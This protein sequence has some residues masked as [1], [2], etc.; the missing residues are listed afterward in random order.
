MV[1]PVC[2][3]AHDVGK[4]CL[5]LGRTAPCAPLQDVLDVAEAQTGGGDILGGAAVREV[6]VDWS[7]GGVVPYVN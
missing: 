4:V 5:A 7:L 1:P 2:H 3:A 6:V